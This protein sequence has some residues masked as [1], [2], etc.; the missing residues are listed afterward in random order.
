MLCVKQLSKSFQRADTRVEALQDV[1]FQVETGAFVQIT[2]PSGSGKST[3]LS[4]LAGLLVPDAGEITYG[5]SCFSALDEEERARFR[6]AHL[7]IVPQT[8][9]LLRA[10][11]VLENVVL[12]W[13]LYPREGD[14]YGRGRYLLE[15]LGIRYLEKAMPSTLSG[16]ELRRVLLARALM[17]DP[18]WVLA[19]EPTADLDPENA[20]A[21]MALL[22]KI[23]EQGKTLIMVTHDRDALSADS[24]RWNMCHG[25][26]SV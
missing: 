14:A 21:V 11:P 19:D 24:L 9:T 1:H 26:L 12:P 6:N 25:V 18:Q 2:G 16:G 15:Q 22:R 5:D 10:L 4:L 8:S 13:Y 23:P 17:N 3:L 20:E 7:G